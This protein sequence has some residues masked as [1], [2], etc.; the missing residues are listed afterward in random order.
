MRLA[1]RAIVELLRT[2]SV[3]VDTDDSRK[4]FSNPSN[5]PIVLKKWRNSQQ[6]ASS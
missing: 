5:A 1:R 2:R 3:S 6:E 4:H